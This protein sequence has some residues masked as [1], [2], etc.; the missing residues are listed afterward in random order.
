M[1][2]GAAKATPK[3]EMTRILA[4]KSE[5]RGQ[6][7]VTQRDHALSTLP[8]ICEEQ[9][10]P[11]A[12]TIRIG[13]LGDYHPE[14]HSHPATNAAIEHAAARLEIEA[15]VR[16][17]PTPTLAE[18]AGEEAMARCDGLWASPGSPYKS[19]LGMLRGIGFARTRKW[20]F[21]GT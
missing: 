3:Q 12:K 2:C 10:R 5:A 19:F 20:P 15:E 4:A 13:I 21:V 6:R 1:G 17:L 18:P 8:V 11:M 14:F 16:W 9:G 7:K